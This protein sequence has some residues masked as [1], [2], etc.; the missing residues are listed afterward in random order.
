MWKGNQE[1]SLNCYVKRTP[2]QVFEGF[3]ERVGL[4]LINMRRL[5]IGLTSLEQK[6][7]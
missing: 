7:N 6:T 1:T 4:E 2:E 5:R 3:G